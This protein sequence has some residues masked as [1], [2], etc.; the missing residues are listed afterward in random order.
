M[1][2]Y[3]IENDKIHCYKTKKPKLSNADHITVKIDNNIVKF[4]FSVR[5]NAS[6][7]YFILEDQWYMTNMINL[8]GLD[9]FHYLYN[10]KNPLFTQKQ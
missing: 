10:M 3:T 8:K 9:L 5:N 6:W 7:Y 1:I 4:H 2:L